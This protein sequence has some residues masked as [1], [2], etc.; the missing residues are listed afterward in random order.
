[1]LGRAVDTM[2][3][4]CSALI[5]VIRQCAG[6]GEESEDKVREPKSEGLKAL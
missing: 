6:G 3:S 2:C 4:Q 1:M 5:C